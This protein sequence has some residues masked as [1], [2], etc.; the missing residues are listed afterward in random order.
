M[1]VRNLRPLLLLKYAEVLGKGRLLD[2]AFPASRLLDCGCVLGTFRSSP[3]CFSFSK[4]RG[5]FQL[6]CAADPSS[7]DGNRDCSPYNHAYVQ[8]STTE[9]RS[10]AATLDTLAFNPYSAMAP[11]LPASLG[12]PSFDSTIGAVFLGLIV[13]TGYVHSTSVAPVVH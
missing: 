12:L 10:P 9:G 5:S 6:R 2:T 8:S 13:G 3:R 11:S 1:R 7:R 4:Y